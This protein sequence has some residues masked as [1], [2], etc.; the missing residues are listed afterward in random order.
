MSNILDSKGF[1]YTPAAETDISKTFARERRRLKA[2]EER[3]KQNEAE[4]R[5]KVALMR[6]EAK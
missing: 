6:R 4:V 3:C 5:T 1:K 2:E